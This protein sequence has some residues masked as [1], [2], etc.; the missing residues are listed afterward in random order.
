MVT[1][2]GSSFIGANGFFYFSD[3]PITNP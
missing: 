1:H 2:N 3:S